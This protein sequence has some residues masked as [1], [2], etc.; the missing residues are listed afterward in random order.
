[1]LTFVWP[2]LGVLPILFWVLKIDLLITQL[3][4]W[5]SCAFCVHPIVYLVNERYSSGFLSA[6]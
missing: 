1:M 6:I 2:S 3:S 4:V 5:L